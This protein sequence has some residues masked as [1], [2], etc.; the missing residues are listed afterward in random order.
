[1]FLFPASRP[2]LLLVYLLLLYEYSESKPI[3]G[4][5]KNTTQVPQSNFTNISSANPATREVDPKFQPSNLPPN[6]TNIAKS[7][8][9]TSPNTQPRVEIP[10][11][12]FYTTNL[13]IRCKDTEKLR[14]GDWWMDPRATEE[15]VPQ[16]EIIDFINGGLSQDRLDQEVTFVRW[17]QVVCKQHC[18]CREDGVIVDATLGQP[19]PNI[20][21][22]TGA[23]YDRAFSALPAIVLAEN[24]HYFWWFRPA[25]P[26]PEIAD[27][28]GDPEPMEIDPPLPLAGPSVPPPVDPSTAP[29]GN[30]N[31]LQQ[32]H[33]RNLLN[34][35]NPADFFGAQNMGQTID[36]ELLQNLDNFHLSG[37]WDYGMGGTD[38]YA[39]NPYGNNRYGYGGHNPYGS[40]SGSGSGSYWG[41]RDTIPDQESGSTESTATYQQE[42]TDG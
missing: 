32:T 12:F 9:P 20:P 1:M 35:F 21:G 25:T 19:Q 14:T 22:A 33:D 30:A 17:K 2:T 41:K 39:T 28:P 7:S 4:S 15:G 10:H 16:N 23:D 37:E 42:G 27:T 31:G 34:T 13:Q 18:G 40:G 6:V 11:N 5:N 29:L 36:P 8:A 26:P 24:P 3:P 38:N